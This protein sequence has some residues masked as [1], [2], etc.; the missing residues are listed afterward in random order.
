MNVGD[1]VRKNG[2]DGIVLAVKSARAKNIVGRGG[3][4]DVI[5]V[6]FSNG[7]MEQIPLGPAF[8]IEVVHESK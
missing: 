8:A 2:Q 4:I 6:M 5:D 7:K 1:I 3:Y